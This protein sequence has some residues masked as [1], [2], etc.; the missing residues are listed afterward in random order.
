MLEGLPLLSLNPSLNW[1]RFGKAFPIA[2]VLCISYGLFCHSA[3]AQETIVNTPQVGNSPL[4]SIIPPETPGPHRFWDTRNR[5]LFAANTILNAAD[6]AVTRSNLQ[7]GGKELNPV[8]RVF[9]RSTQGLAGNFAA[10]T[11]G[12]IGISYMLHRLGH[13][14]LERIA[15]LVNICASGGAVTY[16]L[17]HR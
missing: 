1:C 4:I 16:G 7:A 14:K 6:F 11:A 8:A 10:Q 17:T 2:L 12:A 13:H 15:S 5:V 9:G 3:S